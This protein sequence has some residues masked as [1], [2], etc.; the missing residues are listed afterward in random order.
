M[1]L[2]TDSLPA[3]LQALKALVSAQ[4]AEIERLK[5]MVI[6]PFLILARNRYQATRAN[7]CLGV[8]PPSAIFGR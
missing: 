5:M 2:S 8:M 7:F 3:D 4:R 1:T 6:P